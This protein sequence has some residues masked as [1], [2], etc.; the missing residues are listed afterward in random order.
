MSH[1]VQPVETAH[2]QRCPSAT[3]GRHR[4]VVVEPL[5]LECGLDSRCGAWML[6]LSLVVFF[7][8]QITLAP[9]KCSVRDLLSET[10]IEL[11]EEL[12]LAHGNTNRAR[13]E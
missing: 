4:V 10:V 1:E 8:W 12:P 7:V 3:F 6:W 9:M 5:V 13:L 2:H 11:A